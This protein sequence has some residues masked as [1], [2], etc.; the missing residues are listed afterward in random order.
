MPAP[1]QPQSGRRGGADAG[2]GSGMQTQHDAFQ[3][4]EGVGLVLNLD[5]ILR[6]LKRRRRLILMTTLLVCLAMA[7][8]LQTATRTYT[9]T[10]QLM[11]GQQGQVDQTMDDLV[12]NIDM[13]ARFI[14]GEVT[15]LR[16]GRL[17]VRVA[18]ELELARHPL[19]DPDQQ[20]P[21]SLVARVIGT[22]RGAIRTLLR[23]APP[24]A[25]AEE[26]DGTSSS[27]AIARAASAES[28][29]LGDSAGIVGQLRAGL[30]AQELGR[31]N[32]IEVG[33]TSPDPQIA[34]AVTNKVLDQYIVNQLEADFEAK[35]RLAIW[36]GARIETLRNRLEDS[37]IAVED[38]RAGLLLGD[39][40]TT[41]RLDQQITE[42][43]TR[44]ITARSERAAARA[45]YRQFVETIEKHGKMAAADSLASTFI[46]D[47][48]AQIAELRR[49]EMQVE[50][51]FGP[52]SARL[53]PVRNQISSLDAGI[54]R[55]VERVVAERRNAIEVLDA[56]VASL[57]NSL[58]ETEQMSLVQSRDL[59]KLR[60]LER[61]SEASRLIYENFL[62]RYKQLIGTE[63]LAQ[64][65][66]RVIAYARPPT[67]P[68][69]PRVNLALGLA[70]V[71]GSMLG[72][73]LAFMA[74]F[75]DTGFRT[76]EQ[77]TRAT[78]LR[79]LT[80]FSRF[81]RG[82][83]PRRRLLG[84]ID[85][86]AN[87]HVM[88]E[89]RTLRSF[90]RLGMDRPFGVVAVTSSLPDEGKTSTSLLL[91][92]AAARAGQSCI[93]VDTDVRRPSASRSWFIR[94]GP[95]IVSVMSE[96]ATLD[97][98]IRYDEKTGLSFLP[99]TQPLT[100]PGMLF[101]PERVETLLAALRERYDLVILDTAPVF[102]VTDGVAFAK[103]ADVVLLLIKW[104][105]T[106]VRTVRHCVDLMRDLD[107]DIAGAV[108][109]FVDR[110]RESSYRYRGFAD[111][112]RQYTRKYVE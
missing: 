82:L 11:L 68:S 28:D 47:A 110:R 12:A 5:E 104:G 88:E 49:T 81:R 100:D 101:T 64:A 105:T 22:L 55:E 103:H 106:P 20:E 97:D 93:V 63:T 34:A 98:A 79:V 92:V 46:Q 58:D 61:E 62:A 83:I 91:A 57:E 13:D 99:A 89:A 40:E 23:P 10:G 26:T 45:E 51:R 1:G 37:E 7:A 56:E 4:E 107:I 18:E 3:A 86:R 2:R 41:S 43:T 42:V 60:L 32:V 19:F 54:R 36:L 15:I 59:V 87:L 53:I 44:L 25:P 30:I 73:G 69:S 65:E 52:D 29:I 76:P 39:G 38:F 17:L 21:P 108:L 109:T 75:L 6:I 33:F 78:G 14:E 16:S 31:S 74:E 112:Y 94:S 77:V 24:P 80:S 50:R 90:L 102:S 72:L 35:Q 8:L 85:A 67:A 71:A 27:G 84:L 96:G 70:L 66:A 111:S 95:D 9:A 48:R